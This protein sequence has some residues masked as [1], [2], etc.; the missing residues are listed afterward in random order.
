MKAI[1]TPVSLRGPECIQS[2]ANQIIG[3]CT[4]HVAQIYWGA[5]SPVSRII[6]LCLYLYTHHIYP[7]YS[8][9]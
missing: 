9:P 7:K 1:N 4:L 8:E 2:A 5:D 3:T 6:S